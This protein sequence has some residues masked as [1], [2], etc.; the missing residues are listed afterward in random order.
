TELPKK[1]T[2]ELES[3]CRQMSKACVSTDAV[4]LFGFGSGLSAD[5]E[6]ALVSVPS[7]APSSVIT[8]GYLTVAVCPTASEGKVAIR[9]SPT[10]M[11]VPAGEPFTNVM[12]EPATKLVPGG[13]M[14]V[15]SRLVATPGP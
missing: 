7:C 3:S 4:L 12:Q 13:R 2:P 14:S 10:T 5:T 15:T 6:T 11:Q 8:T 1:T 9:L